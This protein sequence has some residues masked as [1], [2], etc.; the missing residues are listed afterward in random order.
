[1][2]E[3]TET[4]VTEGPAPKPARQHRR[5]NK[6]RPRQAKPPTEAKPTKDAEFAGLTAFD[7]CNACHANIDAA[8]KAQ[9]RLNELELMYPRMLAPPII[10][11]R[12]GWRLPPASVMETDEQY[13]ERN[14]RIADEF[15]KLGA[16]VLG[17]CHIS[18]LPGCAHPHKGGLSVQGKRN[19]KAVQRYERAKKILEHQKIDLRG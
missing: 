11:P 10:D 19:S 17:A 8:Q 6:R 3:H 16:A 7:C 14:P 1:M 5:P 15:R 2:T 9:Y 18:G 12:T 4:T 13:L